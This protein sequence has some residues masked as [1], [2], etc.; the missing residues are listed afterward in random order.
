MTLT[1]LTN[2]VLKNVGATKLEDAEILVLVDMAIY[3]TQMIEQSND[4]QMNSLLR[5]DIVEI[6]NEIAKKV[7][8][9]DV[10]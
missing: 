8:E 9:K 1:G 3:L 7:S 6:K 10:K 5:R 2:E 4:F